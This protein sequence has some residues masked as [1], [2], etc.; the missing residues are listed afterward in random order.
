M[1]TFLQFLNEITVQ[2]PITSTVVGKPK[3][4]LGLQIQPEDEQTYR[5]IVQQNIDNPNTIDVEQSESPEKELAWQN[6]NQAVSNYVGKQLQQMKAQAG[7]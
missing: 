1:K 7:L 3:S 2:P 6:V 5:S 4:L